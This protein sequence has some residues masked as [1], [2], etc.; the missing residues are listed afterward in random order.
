MNTYNTNDGH[1]HRCKWLIDS[2][3]NSKG[4]ILDVGTND[5]FMFRDKLD[6]LDVTF[7]DIEFNFPDSY[8][9]QIKFV[10][11]NAESLP[12]K[13]KSFNA[14][15]AGDILEHVN[16]PVKAL[17]EFHRVGVQ[18]FITVPNEYNWTDE[19]RP[20]E[21][22][23]HVRFYDEELVREHLKLANIFEYE[24]HMIEGGGWSFFCVQF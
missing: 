14:I 18:T 21:N 6:E 8:R 2:A 12:F 19:K 9:N 23:G 13:D 20:F 16:Y 15:I 5:G 4:S 10:K 11:G 22:T 24:I 7:Y 1:F 3:T 17:K